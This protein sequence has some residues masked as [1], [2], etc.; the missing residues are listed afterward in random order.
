[1]CGHKIAKNAGL[2]QLKILELL[3]PLIAKIHE[4]IQYFGSGL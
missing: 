3:F 4:F 2:P 1:M